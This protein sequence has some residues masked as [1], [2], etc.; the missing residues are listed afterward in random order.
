[1]I[2]RTLHLML[3]CAALAPWHPAS[4]ANFHAL[5]QFNAPGGASL[6]GA[7]PYA[8]LV[9]DEAGNLFGTLYAGAAAGAGGVFMLA[10]Q[11]NGGWAETLI[12]SFSTT[13]GADGAHPLGSLILGP[14]G[15]LYGTTSTG[16]GPGNTG[17][18][19]VFALRPPLFPGAG[20]TETVL[21]VFPG[22]HGT[23]GAPAAHLL[24]DASG[25]L[26]GTT[27][28]GGTGAGSVFRLAPPA[29]GQANWVRTD[30]HVFGGS[31]DGQT[32]ISA[33]TADAAGALYGTAQDS[34][35]RQ[36]GAGAVYRLAPPRDG[37]TAWTETIVFTFPASGTFGSMPNGDLLMDKS[38]AL[39]GTASAGGNKGA[40]TVFRLAAQAPG[41]A[42]RCTVLHN[43]TEH[44]GDGGPQGGVVFGRGGA[45]I[46]TTANAARRQQGAVFQLIPGTDAGQSWSETVL[47][48]FPTRPAGGGLFPVGDL[49]ADGN[50]DYFG[51]TE[52]GGAGGVGTVFEVRP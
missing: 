8:G 42:W 3:A 15:V 7:N 48:R 2:R 19:T 30:L 13:G 37:E 41:Q 44:F 1:M 36:S 12:H 27:T 21:T 16:G 11:A 20:W 9:R 22:K 34:A 4:A 33:L 23:G 25:A 24:L 40:G 35:D 10:P 45:L 51:V 38:G 28:M 18:G 31:G 6:D 52:M 5:Y 32:P 47:A 46:G 14:A 17:G 43:F 29:P 49:V 26:Y 50:G 39:Y